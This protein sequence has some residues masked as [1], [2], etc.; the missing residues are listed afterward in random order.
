M[1][2]GSRFRRPWASALALPLWCQLLMSR[3]C[4]GWLAALL[5]LEHL[6]QRSLRVTPLQPCPSLKAMLLLSALLPQCRS[7]A[8]LAT[9]LQH[10]GFS[11][12]VAVLD[13]EHLP[14]HSLCMATWRCL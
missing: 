12:L 14:S 11:P 3:R 8:L 2:S 1:R 5:G 13:L 9:A 7:L 10:S 6:S 4:L